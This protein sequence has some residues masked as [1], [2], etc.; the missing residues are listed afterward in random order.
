MM[1]KNHDQADHSFIVRIHI[2]SQCPIT[3]GLLELF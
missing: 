1:S 3:D 2:G